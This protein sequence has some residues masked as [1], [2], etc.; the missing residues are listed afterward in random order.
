MM[1]LIHDVSTDGEDPP[2]FI[3]LRAARLASPNGADYSGVRA[4]HP[5][6]IV[7]LISPQPPER[8]FEAA[9]A[10]AREMHWQIAD[11][12]AAEGRIEATAVTRIFRFKD[13]IVIRIRP[14]SAGSR[15]DA[16]SAS[17][18]GRSDLGANARRLH[19]F[20]DKTKNCLKSNS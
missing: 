4:G 12:S 10:A 8:V 17:R 5:P 7:P 1:K 3:A 13:D 6:G 14:H 11:A 2:Q 16:R 15:L 20:F 9:L 19:T 18:V